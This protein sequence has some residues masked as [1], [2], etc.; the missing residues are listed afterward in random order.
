MKR[1]NGI[2]DERDV[3][4]WAQVGIATKELTYLLAATT[5]GRYYRFFR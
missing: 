1:D 3:L 2:K 4:A 5:K